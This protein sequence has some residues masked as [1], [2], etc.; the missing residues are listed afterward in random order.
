MTRSQERT[1]SHTGMKAKYG[2]RV[3]QAVET[4]K[5]LHEFYATKELEW[6]QKMEAGDGD[7]SSEWMRYVR[8]AN[9]LQI[10]IDVLS[11]EEK[12]HG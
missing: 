9:S 5:Q 7:A 3:D 10:A 8:E 1:S 4:L 6:R 2:L 11:D 12:N